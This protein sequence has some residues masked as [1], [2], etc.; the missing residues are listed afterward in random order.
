MSAICTN[1]TGQL[2][3]CGLSNSNAASQGIQI[4]AT[5]SSAF[6]L[7]G[8]CTNTSALTL[9]QPPFLSSVFGS[10]ACVVSTNLTTSASTPISILSSDSTTAGTSV[11]QTCCGIDSAVAT[12]N[13][14]A[15]DGGGCGFAYCNVTS[16]AAADGFMACL[17]A[18]ATGVKGQC[19]LS[20]ATAPTGGT[21][22][23]A[24][25]EGGRLGVD[26]V[27]LI[28]MGMLAGLVTGV[29]GLTLA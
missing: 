11:F 21:T 15:K 2:V 17:N 8:V 10:R 28:G 20:T 19:F 9:V 1:S 24:A 29:G 5:A 12:F 22:S 25:S 23:K 18:T 4:A 6:D 27:S 13:E 7:Y 16:Q 14:T 26:K 3:A